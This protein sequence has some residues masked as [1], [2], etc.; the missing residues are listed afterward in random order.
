MCI[1]SCRYLWMR[2]VLTVFQNVARLALYVIK[3]MKCNKIALC[4]L[5]YKCLEKVNPILEKA[6]IV[7]TCNLM[8][9]F[10]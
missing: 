6:Q 5:H 3:I 2:A 10:A 7:K 8:D 1:L 9:L 4:W